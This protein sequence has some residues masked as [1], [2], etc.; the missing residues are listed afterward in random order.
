MNEPK[1]VQSME[2]WHRDDLPILCTWRKLWR[3]VEVGVDRAVWASL[4]LDRWQGREYWGVDA[5]RPYPEMAYDR[6]ADYSFALANLARHSGRAKLIRGESREAAALFPDD[7][8]DFIYVDGAHDYDSVIADLRAW[9][10][11]LQPQ[12]ILAGHDW[13]DQPKHAGVKQAVAEFAGE[14]GQTVYLTAVEGYGQEECP[15]W[16]LYRSGMPGADWRRC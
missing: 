5:W 15:S 16:Y 9:W 1:I 4:F 8:V 14:I 3:A 11:A 10:H 12:G 13:D 7:S 6:E 2:I